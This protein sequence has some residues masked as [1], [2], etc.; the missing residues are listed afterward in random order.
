MRSPNIKRAKWLDTRTEAKN[1][2]KKEVENSEETIEE[3][4]KRLRR[5]K[6]AEFFSQKCPINELI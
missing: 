2:V 5:D 1:Q 6:N 4:D 3:T